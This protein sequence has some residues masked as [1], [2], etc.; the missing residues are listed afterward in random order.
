L[1]ASSGMAISC[2]QGPSLHVL[3]TAYVSSVQT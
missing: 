1:V 2:R 3:P